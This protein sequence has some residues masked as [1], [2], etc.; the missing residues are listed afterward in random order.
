MR[1]RNFLAGAL[2]LVGLTGCTNSKTL[3]IWG[4]SGAI[5]GRSLKEFEQRTG[6]DYKIFATPHELWQALPD[7]KLENPPAV[8]SLGDSWLDRAIQDN[9][10]QPFTPALLQQIPNWQELGKR[11]QTIGQRRGVVWGIPY[12]WGGTAIV[13]RR[14]LVPEPIKA[15]ADLWR[16]ELA[17]KVIVLDDASEV[18]GLTLKKLG[19]KYHLTQPESVPNL[20][21][22]LQALQRQVLTYSS[23][24]YIQPLL[25]DEAWVSVGWTTDVRRPLRQNPNLIAE[26]PLEGTALWA[27]MW[28]I[29]KGEG[30]NLLAVADWVNA[31]LSVA[32]ASQLSALTDAI[33]PRPDLSLPANVTSDRLKFWEPGLLERSEFISD[34][35]PEQRKWQGEMW[36]KLRSS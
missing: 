19:Q 28:V 26:I 11:W 15:W 16:P 2:A 4:L 6:V 12:R 32:F 18:I 10:I 14:D 27:D 30:G 22:E 33:S 29:P 20:W 7:R 34:L 13:Y 5:P 21:A 9:L 25:L 8:V 1:R 31:T 35:S 23:T 3:R 36:T 17:R 24:D